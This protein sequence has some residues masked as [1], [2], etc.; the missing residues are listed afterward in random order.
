M[1]DQIIEYLMDLSKLKDS[2]IYEFA[3]NFTEILYK[4][5]LTDYL[6]LYKKKLPSNYTTT[7]KRPNSISNS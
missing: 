2:N 7:C 1:I 6:R 4:P 5:F 3:L